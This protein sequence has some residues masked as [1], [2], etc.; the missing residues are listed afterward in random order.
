MKSVNSKKCAV[1]KK[2]GPDLDFKKVSPRWS[3]IVVGLK[4]HL[5]IENTQFRSQKLWLDLDH[6]NPLNQ[7]SPQSLFKPQHPAV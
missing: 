3:K 2:K 6:K 1:I 4:K 5:D 7:K